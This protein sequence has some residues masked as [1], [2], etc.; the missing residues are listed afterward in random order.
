MMPDDFRQYAELWQEQIEPEELAEL[1]AMAKNIERTARRK[2]LLDVSLALICAGFACFILWSHPA[3]LQVKFGYFLLGAICL[4]G[5]WRRH[6]ITRASR[7]TAIDD[8][9]VFFEKAIKNLRAELNLS[10]TSVSV[11]VPMG[12]LSIVLAGS[13]RG[14]TAMELVRKVFDKNPAIIIFVGTVLVLSGIYFIRENFKLRE[15]LRRLERM[16][17]EWE[18]PQEPDAEEGP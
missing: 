18:E 1:Q 14:V 17:R 10:T 8:P 9:R 13:L 15:Q 3:S 5:A 6:Q 4:W 7:A 12:I 16:R 11:A 2:W